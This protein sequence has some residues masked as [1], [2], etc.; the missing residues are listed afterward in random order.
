VSYADPEQGHIGGIYQ[1]MNWVYVGK[2]QGGTAQ[3]AIN[4]HRIHKR[5]AFDRYG[6]ASALINGGTWVQPEEKH[7]YLYPLD[8]VMKAQ[9]A[10]LAKP[11]PKRAASIDSDASGVQSEEGSANLTA[12]LHV[13]DDPITAE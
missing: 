2:T 1:A 4:G 3:I 7:K 8:K 10:P 6:S 11:Y 5:T 9:I 12:T 13:D